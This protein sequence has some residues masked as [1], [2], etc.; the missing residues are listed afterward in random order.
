[1]LSNE[2]VIALKLVENSIKAK[3]DYIEIHI[4]SNIIEVKDNGLGIDLCLNH[5]L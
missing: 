3:A 1:M 4:R 2:L 5:C